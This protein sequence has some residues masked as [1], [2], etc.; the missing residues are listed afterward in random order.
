MASRTRARTS[1]SARICRSDGH[2]PGRRI[3]LTLVG[4]A[5]VAS[6][7][8]DRIYVSNEDGHSV[9]VL[10]TARSGADAKVIATI[11]VGKRPRGMKLSRDGSRLYVAV[12]GLPKCPPSVP[13]EEC[14]KLERDL[15][16]DGIAIV[17]TASHKVLR[18]LRAGSDPEQFAMSADG[19]RLFV[20]N[21]DTATV[22]VVEIESGTVLEKIAVG[23]EPEGVGITPDGRW[24]LVTNESDSSVSMIDTSSFKVVRSVPV[25]KRPRD[26]AFTPDSRIAYVSGEL[27]A[28]LYRI[29]VP[30]G[31]PIERVLQLREQTRPMGVILDAERDRL[32]LST[33]RGGTVAVI[34]PGSGKLLQE[35][36]VGTRPWGMALSRDGRWL[37]TA[38]GPS[39]DVSIVDTSTLRA[40]RQV[41]V[42]QSPWGVVIG[43]EPR[44]A[45]PDKPAQ[46]GASDTSGAESAGA[47]CVG[48]DFP[49]ELPELLR[50]LGV[51]ED[52]SALAGQAGVL[53]EGRSLH[54][55]VVA[56]P[57]RDP[58]DCTGALVHARALVAVL[59]HALVHELDARNRR[60]IVHGRLVGEGDRHGAEAEGDE[61]RHECS[62]MA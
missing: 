25:G 21:E 46:P 1:I 52:S 35:V 11:P 17:D 44:A 31:E 10:D 56:Q 13:D 50:L 24:V 49:I 39:N 43:P 60:V 9:T 53:R 19:R 6:A 12:S 15:T 14:A 8:A 61:Q 30:Q 55:I 16:A 41:Q 28:S 3:A 20:A 54:E 42:G 4:V 45:R 29:H 40:V 2:G 48:L 47:V 37:Y 22:S 27:D 32:Y 57:V 18:L 62:L 34:D 7:H 26:V 33:G 58:V 51:A 59:R 23:R 5:L 38:N 36:R